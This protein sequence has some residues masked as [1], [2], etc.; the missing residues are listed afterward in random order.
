[1]IDN[2]LKGTSV[3]AVLIGAQTASR[4]WVKYEIDKSVELLLDAADL[5]A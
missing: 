2:A 5:L 1:L 3:T 4:R